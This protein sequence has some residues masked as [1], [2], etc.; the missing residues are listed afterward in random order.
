MVESPGSLV[1][2]VPQCYHGRGGPCL[3]V[4][5]AGGL[6]SDAMRERVIDIETLSGRM[7]TFVT[8]P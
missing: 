4:P 2:R 1:V 8:H 5:V 6:V 3:D 7:P